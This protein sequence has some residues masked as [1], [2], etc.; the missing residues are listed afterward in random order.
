[1]TL[2]LCKCGQPAV[3]FSPGSE[4]LRAPGDIIVRR[5]CPVTGRCVACWSAPRGAPILECWRCAGSSAD[6]VAFGRTRKP[7]GR[8]L[9]CVECAAEPAASV[10]VFVRRTHR[11][12]EVARASGPQK[13][14]DDMARGGL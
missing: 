14:L 7:R 9:L 10:P 5:G 8:P 13:D 3:I 4:P 2:P 11:R 12:H 1:M 6:G